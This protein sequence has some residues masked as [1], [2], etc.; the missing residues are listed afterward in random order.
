MSLIDLFKQE[1]DEMLKTLISWAE[2]NTYSYNL[3]GLDQMLTILKKA[4]GELATSSIEIK[5]LESHQELNYKAELETKVLGKA[6]SIKLKSPDKPLQKIL[7]MGHMDTVYPP[8]LGF[9]KCTRLDSNKLNGPGVADLK[10]GLVVLLYALKYFQT[11]EESKRLAIEIFINPDEE[12]GSTGSQKYFAELAKN[13]NIALILEP[14]LEDG[15]IAYQRSGTGNFQFLIK[16][17]AAHVGRNFDDGV[18]A[19]VAASAL[20]VELHELNKLNGLIFNSGKINGGGPLNVVADTCVLGVNIRVETIEHISVA[21]NSIASIIESIETTYK[22]KI[23]RYGSFNRPPK[24]PN[25]DLEVLYKLVE[26]SAQEL[27]L[28]ISRKKT[29]GCCDGNNLFHLGLP[30]IDSLGVRG[31]N[32]HSTNEFMC[33]D[34]LNERAALLV[35]ILKKLSHA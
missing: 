2:I 30:N 14:S 32:I 4:F 9:N 17:K 24:I 15:S 25:Q 29:G 35:T 21:E 31:A 6:L 18:N 11:L 19:I 12:I 20:A 26:E 7:L 33:I 5:E 10:G 27:G 23:E 16:G 13:N 34:S 8:E 3:T 1:E 22:V 28:T